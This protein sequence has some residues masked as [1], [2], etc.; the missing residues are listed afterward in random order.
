M[1]FLLLFR[2][3][4]DDFFRYG[5]NIKGTEEDPVKAF[6]VLMSSFV[7]AFRQAVSE[8]TNKRLEAEKNAKKAIEQANRGKKEEVLTPSTKADGTKE[9]A[10]DNLFANFNNAQKATAGDLMAEF[11][12]KQQ[13]RNAIAT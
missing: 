7:R 3:F 10:K 4:F 5:E 11:K 6:F 8:N 1:R 12:M 2:F 9:K 13:R